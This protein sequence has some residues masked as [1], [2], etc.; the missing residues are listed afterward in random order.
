MRQNTLTTDFRAIWP[1]IRRQQQIFLVNQAPLFASVMLTSGLLIAVAFWKFSP[2]WVI[3]LWYSLVGVLP[4]F[5]LEAWWKFRGRPMPKVT[6]GKTLDRA[7]WGSLY[8][9]GL[10]GATA[11]LFYTPDSISH[12]MLLAVVLTGMAAGTA[13]VM[14]PTPS[15][16][17][18][19]LIA[20][21][22]ALVLRLLWE[23][24]VT[25]LVIAIMAVFFCF[26]LVKGSQVN[27]KQFAQIIAF[28]NELEIARTHLVNAI[29]S[30]NDAFA[31]FDLQGQLAIANRRFL[32]WFPGQT[33]VQTG[34]TQETVYR[35]VNDVWLQGSVRPIDGGG[36]VS[37][38]T[39]VTALKE[40]EDQLLTAS[41]QAELARLQAEEANRAK[42]E[43]LANMSHELRTPLNAIMGFS[44][45]MS[46]E[47]FGPI[48]APKYKE[49]LKDIHTSASH[50]LSII[51][52]IL[53]LSKIESLNYKIEL[54]E[55]D[56][57]E[58]VNWVVALA[59]QKR[60]AINGRTIDVQVADEARHLELDL[61]A[62]KQVL[63]NLV[64]NAMKF[65]PHEGRVG[66]R[67]V[68]EADGSVRITV[69]DTGIGIPKDRLE[70]VKRPFTQFES[71]FHKKFQGTGLGLS[72]SDA[73]VKMQG[74]HLIVD[75]EE[76]K[77][78]QVTV[79]FPPERRVG[80][81]IEEIRSIG[82][83]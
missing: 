50:L 69:W 10:W 27:F 34:E 62:M 77:G 28:S 43:F 13:A 11:I 78:T 82:A 4:I 45:L 66:I 12:Q 36:Y 38:Y 54:E 31:I 7:K 17:A 3:L 67:V 59:T 39:D 73:L 81:P 76:G 68:A 49:Y 57:G 29:E 14:G 37:V 26:A 74:G 83:A 70:W 33:H 80:F 52:D 63:L 79:I 1:E 24:Q 32:R 19:F 47:L 61:R 51:S 60:D 72:I 6:S 15:L 65:T 9:G 64:S 46:S 2:H 71:A 30:T 25:H 55:I 21:L 8:L 40:R 42:S 44:E 20:C 18:R 23:G 5:Q 48:G 35:Q 75:S 16:C 56:L 22:S 53:D 41:H 58:V